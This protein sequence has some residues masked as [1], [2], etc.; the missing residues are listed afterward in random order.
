MLVT[1]NPFAFHSSYQ[2]SL[3]YILSVWIWAQK[4][5]SCS[6]PLFFNAH[7]QHSLG[8]FIFSWII[9]WQL[10]K[11]CFLQYVLTIN[12]AIYRAIKSVLWKCSAGHCGLLFKTQSIA[13]QWILKTF[14]RLGVYSHF[15]MYLIE[16]NE[17]FILY[18]KRVKYYAFRMVQ[19]NSIHIHFYPYLPRFPFFCPA[20]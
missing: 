17:I 10:P 18:P 7:C 8:A 9:P 14:P 4:H 13:F 2:S 15:S 3:C 19:P 20:F 11:W 1:M 16:L 12:P 6:W 5:L